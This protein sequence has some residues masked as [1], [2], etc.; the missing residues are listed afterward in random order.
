VEDLGGEC[1]HSVDNRDN[2]ERSSRESGNILHGGH[3]LVGEVGLHTVDPGNTEAVVDQTAVNT[4]DETVG[5]DKA[6]VESIDKAVGLNKTIFKSID[7]AIGLDKTIAKSV[8]K[9]VGL[10]P[11]IPRRAFMH[12]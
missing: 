6:V 7:K 2:G 11:L 4:I 8:D 12:G 10:N 9:A 3:H 1:S 5:L